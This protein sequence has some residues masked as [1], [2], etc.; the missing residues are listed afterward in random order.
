MTIHA[1]K[2]LEFDV[3]MCPALHRQ[4]SYGSPFTYSEGVGP[5]RRKIYDLRPSGKKPGCAPT[6]ATVADKREKSEEALRVAYVAITRA[7]HR[8]VIW[9]P[10]TDGA[11]KSPLGTF[12]GTE[13]TKVDPHDGP[14]MAALEERLGPVVA[15]DGRRVFD[16]VPI[17]PDARRHP[18]LQVTAGDRT[19][20]ELAV[21]TLGRTLDRRDARWSFSRLTRH[22]RV[23]EVHGGSTEDPDDPTLGDAG[24]G[25]EGPA[26]AIPLAEVGMGTEFGTL[27][28]ETLEGA[29]LSAD[30]LSAE[31]S[32]ALVGAGGPDAD[33]ERHRRIVD[34]L[35]QAALTPM[36]PV[37]ENH[38]LVDIPP[39][40]HLDE[41]DFEFSLPPASQAVV[42]GRLAS[43]IADHL[44]DG[45]PLLPWTRR[46]A[47]AGDELELGGFM[48]GSIDGLFRIR[49]GSGDPKY[50]VVDYKTNWLG[51]YGDTLRIDHYSPDRL[52]TA[53]AHHHYPLQALIYAVATH[54]FLRWRLAD[55]NPH[56][57]LG[58]AAYL[59]LR[60]MV[61]AETPREGEHPYGV[62]SWPMPAD[63]VI[64]ASDLLAHLGADTP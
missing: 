38:R 23:D 17:D 16:I 43:L 47:V 13:G 42:A 1:A 7:R 15:P 56:L 59:F 29:D 37:F 50:V 45:D 33:T 18:G 32:A 21:A 10:G 63:L 26:V 24:T 3:V 5:D 2:G 36:G 20:V 52:V 22:T 19:D 46:L 64:E 39:A 62:A 14:I 6:E 25:D 61:G 44:N 60:G 54:R 11:S 27:V 30:D 4:A 58:G 28:H 49:N 34:G 41:M 48:V 55:Y 35:V 12:F 8:C 53:M 51:T 40:D 31:L 57:H 9:Y